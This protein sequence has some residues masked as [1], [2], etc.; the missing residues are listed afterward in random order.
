M[1]PAMPLTLKL[2]LITVVLVAIAGCAGA[3]AKPA[4]ALEPAVPAAGS[5]RHF[6]H[7]I[8][9]AAP[10]GRIWGIWMDAR[11][12]PAWDPELREVSSEAALAVGVEGRL[13]PVRG[14]ASRFR[15]T[16][17]IAGE[18]YTFETRLPA[19][20]LRITRTVTTTPEGSRFTHDVQFSGPLG[21][22]FAAK[23]GPAF[24][25]AL[26]I[27]MSQLAALATRP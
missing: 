20:T 12:W 2:V 22:V 14:R 27:A 18:R 10:P 4:A 1:E 26:P 24:R 11:G 15:V 17:L 9:V 3:S 5:N 13:V 6:S 19:A 21:R 7:T 25:R 8:E 23:F 16:E